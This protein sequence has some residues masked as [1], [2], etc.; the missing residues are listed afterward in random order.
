MTGVTLLEC[1]QQG[2]WSDSQVRVS[3]LWLNFLELEV[4]EVH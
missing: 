3:E 4:V 1:S 2:G